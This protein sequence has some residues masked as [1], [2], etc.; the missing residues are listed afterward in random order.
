MR[1]ARYIGSGAGLCLLAEDRATPAEVAEQ[2]LNDGVVT[3]RCGRRA[4]VDEIKNLTVLEAVLGDPLDTANRREIYRDNLAIDFFGVEE[5]SLFAV[6]GN[7][8]IGSA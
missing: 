4:A 6:R 5:R 8:V 3:L 7:V 2:H 1:Q